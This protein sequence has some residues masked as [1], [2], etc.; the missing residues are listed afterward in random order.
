MSFGLQWNQ[1]FMKGFVEGEHTTETCLIKS[2]SS[3]NIR[4]Y[5]NMLC[6]KF[7]YNFSFGKQKKHPVQ[8]IK[9]SD[10]DS[11]LLIK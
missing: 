9:N 6:L 4:D 11:G 5:S 10:T 8:K 3:N 7:S 2:T 1:P